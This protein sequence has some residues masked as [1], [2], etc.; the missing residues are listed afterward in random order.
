MFCNVRGPQRQVLH[1]ALRTPL[2]DR[3][4]L[5]LCT[6]FRHRLPPRCRS[7]V[8]PSSP[9]TIGVASQRRLRGPMD[10]TAF[11]SQPFDSPLLP[12][13]VSARRPPVAGRKLLLVEF[14]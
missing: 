12:M 8:P 5:M 3:S 6:T 4:H 2:L 1:A 13:A 7:G 9:G 14:P 10:L 11:A